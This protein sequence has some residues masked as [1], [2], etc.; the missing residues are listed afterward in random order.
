MFSV[1]GKL[2]HWFTPAS[3]IMKKNGF[4]HILNIKVIETSTMYDTSRLR[5][6]KFQVDFG[7]IQCCVSV[8]CMNIG[9]KAKEV[10]I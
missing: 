2:H 5:I 8:S 4:Y 10:F 9:K 7:Y 3:L 1:D 6:C